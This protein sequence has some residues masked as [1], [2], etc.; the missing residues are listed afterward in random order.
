[1]TQ[2][3]VFGGLP[4]ASPSPASERRVLEHVVSG[5]TLRFITR[6]TEA[7]RGRPTTPSS[8]K[9]AAADE[10]TL[11]ERLFDALSA[12]KIMTA[13]VAMHLDREWRL[14]IRRTLLLLLSC[15]VIGS[16]GYFEAVESW[17]R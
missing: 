10:G 17:C 16:T 7:L 8:L 3:A 14:C 1:M 4:S 12:A 5:D 6:Q 9:T 11:A 15:F 2:M 13:Q